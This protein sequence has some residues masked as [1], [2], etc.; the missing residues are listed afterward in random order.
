[1][2]KSGIITPNDELRITAVLDHKEENLS[3]A[4]VES[5]V[6]FLR[7]YNPE[8]AQVLETAIR[9]PDGGLKMSTVEFEK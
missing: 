7:S 5:L 8:R 6:K 2:S 4:E 1:M 9:E 3:A